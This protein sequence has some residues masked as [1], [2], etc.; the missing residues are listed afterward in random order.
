MKGSVHEKGSGFTSFIASL[1][2]NALLKYIMFRH[3]QSVTICMPHIQLKVVMVWC[4]IDK[5]IHVNKEKNKQ[6]NIFRLDGLK[7]N[8]VLMCCPWSQDYCKRFCFAINA[9]SSEIWTFGKNDAIKYFDYWNT[10]WQMMSTTTV[11]ICARIFHKHKLTTIYSLL[12][13]SSYDGIIRRERIL[14]YIIAVIVFCRYIGLFYEKRVFA[15]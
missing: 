6:K 5:P 3:I 11:S 12:S 1:E 14:L 15:F 9:I 7:P 8:K 4:G 2:I 10:K 13:C